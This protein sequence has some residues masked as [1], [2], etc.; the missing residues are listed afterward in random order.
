MPDG[1]Q[2]VDAESIETD[3]YPESGVHHAKLTE[4]LGAEDMRV[5][6]IILEPGE[7]V[8][9]HTHERQEE[10]YVCTQGP[11]EVYIDGTLHE[12]PEGG[13][14]R[15]GADVPRQMLNTTED[16]TH[17]WVMFGAPPIGTIE[18][19]GEYVVAEGGYDME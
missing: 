2:I 8:G 7:I 14:V 6:A 16:Q 1:Y 3:P 18:D 5:N 13:V 10:I 17:R 4:A 9:Y 15:L 19:F 12:V 11:G